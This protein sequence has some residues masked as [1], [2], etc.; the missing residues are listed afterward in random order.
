MHLD[1]SKTEKLSSLAK[2]ILEHLE[3]VANAARGRLDVS[4][5]R[6]T[7]ASALIGGANAMVGSPASQNLATIVTVD[8]A[9]VERL[10]REPFVARVVVRFEDDP[11]QSYHSL[12]ITRA[13]A[14]SWIEIENARFATYTAPL[15]R[16]AELPVG[17]HLT[18]RFGGDLRSVVIVERTRLNPSLHYS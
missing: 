12:Y 16:V 5:P 6:A 8:R 18:L 11:D 4:R 14:P 3:T 9:E 2:T 13:S 10:S 17:C 7:R 1:E 15:G